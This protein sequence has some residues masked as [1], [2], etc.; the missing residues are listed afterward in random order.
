MRTPDDSSDQSPEHANPQHADPADG[1]G[2]KPGSGSRGR[3]FVPQHAGRA[4][5][6]LLGSLRRFARL[7]RQW[8][9]PL[10]AAVLAWLRGSVTAGTS[11]RPA[12]GRRMSGNLH[13]VHP[14]MRILQLGTSALATAV[15]GVFVGTAGAPPPDDAGSHADGARSPAVRQWASAVSAET[16][17]P[18]RALEAYAGAAHALDEKRPGC[19]PPWQLLAGIGR[20]ESDHARFGGAVL[21]DNGRPSEPIIGIKLDG[22]GVDTVTDTDNGRLDGDVRHDRA[23]GP[24]QFIPS[25]WSNWATDGN[26]DGRTN[27]QNLN[28]AAATAGNY[29]CGAVGGQDLSAPA[30]QK[31]ALMTYNQSASYGQLVMRTANG[32]ES[33]TAPPPSV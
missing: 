26:G 5:R 14:R 24:M 25:T 18:A 7:G 8:A 13:R 20:V 33:A 23:V 6:E 27:P 2:T 19:S 4:A 29:L 15:L 28:D 12:M 9:A 17:V 1:T 31:D 11:S 3:R 10:V 32:Y 16:D 21:Q 22:A 30:N